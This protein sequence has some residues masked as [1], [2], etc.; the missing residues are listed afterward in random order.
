MICIIALVVFG[1]LGIFSVSHRKIAAEALDCVFR[2]VT[3]RKCTTGLDKRLKSQITGRLM[4]KSPKIARFTFRHF[5]VISWFFT[6]LL[7]ASLISSGFSIYNFTVYGNCNGPESTGFCVLDIAN[8]FNIHDSLS[9]C[10]DGQKP[11]VIDLT[12]PIIR[13]TDPSLGPTDAKVVLVEF[14]CFKCSYTAEAEEVLQQVLD[15]YPKVL[16]I[17]KDFPLSQHIGSETA[18]NA[19]QCVYNL[20]PVAY[21]DFRTKL[22][23]NQDAQTAENLFA[24]AVDLGVDEEDFLDC[25]GNMLYENSILQGIED[26]KAAGIYGTPTFFINDHALVGPKPFRAFKNIIEKELKESEE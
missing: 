16:F 6:I 5:E 2:R 4:K 12:E 11:S 25:Y 26:G 24:W 23:E 8:E 15:E 10:G 3:F 18:S 1:I 19:A 7:F 14:G 17:Y 21:W 22:L 13:F 20:K 9:T